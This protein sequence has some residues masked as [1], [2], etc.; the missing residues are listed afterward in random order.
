MD[1]EKYV[2]SFVISGRNLFGT[3]HQRLGKSQ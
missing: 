2:G 1:I 3:G